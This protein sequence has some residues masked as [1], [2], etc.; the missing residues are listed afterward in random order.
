MELIDQSVVT[1]KKRMFHLLLCAC[2]LLCQTLELLA[3]KLELP[4]PAKEQRIVPAT[5][6]PLPSVAAA[7]AE[8]APPS[9]AAPGPSADVSAGVTLRQRWFFTGPG[10]P[11]HHVEDGL[12]NGCKCQVGDAHESHNFDTKF[13]LLHTDTHLLHTRKHLLLLT[14][15]HPLHTVSD[16]IHIRP[17]LLHTDSCIQDLMMCNHWDVY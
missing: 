6:A 10:H 14:T 5:A 8:E 9:A 3:G 15:S 7:A 16:L 12:R 4:Q 11:L 1:A 17:Y 13:Y 2:A